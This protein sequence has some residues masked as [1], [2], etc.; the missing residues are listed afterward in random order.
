[1][2]LIRYIGVASGLAATVYGRLWQVLSLL[3]LGDRYTWS[4]SVCVCECMYM[5]ACVRMCMCVC[6]YSTFLLIL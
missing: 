6:V 5:C 4:Y 3:K 2:G 1:M